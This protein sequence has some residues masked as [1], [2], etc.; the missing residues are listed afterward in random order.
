MSR[1]TKS[2]IVPQFCLLLRSLDYKLNVTGHNVSD[3]KIQVFWN[4][5]S[6][7]LIHGYSVRY[8]ALEGDWVPTAVRN[9]S[10]TTHSLLI[11][12]LRPSTVY[13]VQ[14]TALLTGQIIREE[15]NIST[16]TEPGMYEWSSFLSC[17]ANN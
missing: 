11:E 7:D 17:K 3:S 9:V 8:W 1:T 14:V 5:L 10:K 6:L 12:R 15:A 16:D 2:A 4:P 13:V